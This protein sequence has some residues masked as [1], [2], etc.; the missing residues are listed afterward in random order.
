M[1]SNSFAEGFCCQKFPSIANRGELNYKRSTQ[2]RYSLVQNYPIVIAR[3]RYDVFREGVMLLP[4]LRR[5][6]AVTRRET[7]YE[8]IQNGSI[9]CG[10][11]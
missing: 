4:V 5:K 11:L 6:L 7:L 3:I 9:R 2:S 8:L 10:E 1:K